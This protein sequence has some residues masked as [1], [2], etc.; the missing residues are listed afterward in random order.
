M[1]RCLGREF[2]IARHVI[3]MK[4]YSSMAEWHAS[5]G[6]YARLEIPQILLDVD[7]CVYADGDT[8]FTADP[9]LLEDVWNSRFAIMGHEDYVSAIDNHKIQRE[10]HLKRGLPWDD[11]THICA[12]FVLMN[13]QWFREND[14]TRRCFRFIL[15]HMPPYN[16]QD[17][18]NVVCMGKIGLLPD[19]WGAFA[20]FSVPSQGPGC[21]HYVVCRPW[22]M[23]WNDRL[24][25]DWTQQIWFSTLR[26]LYGFFP[27]RCEKS[28]LVYMF[29]VVKTW[30]WEAIYKCVSALP[31]LRSRYSGVYNILWNRR[32]IKKFLL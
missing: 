1:H 12:G 3:D 20:M 2:A 18:L 17:A 21:F 8:L 14:G 15:E 27:W 6:V 16:D 30:F 7:W 32:G 24:S 26:K 19:A 9:F 28:F 13:L 25:Y 4:A 5:K 23:D 29:A 31:P 11:A 10:W 22:E